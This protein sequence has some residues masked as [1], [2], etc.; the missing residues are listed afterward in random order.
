VAG[1]SITFSNQTSLGNPFPPTGGGRLLAGECVT[2]A[3]S[4]T[5]IGNLCG[6]FP[7]TVVACGT[8]TSPTS[9]QVCATNSAVCTVCTAP[10]ISVTKLCPATNGLPG[11][12]LTF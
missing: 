8:D 2:Y 10:A 3:G 1:A 4:F 9:K 6:P 11:G 12:V 7:D 5:P